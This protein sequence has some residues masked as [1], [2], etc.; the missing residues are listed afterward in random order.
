MRR[1]L[2]L[3]VVVLAIALTGCATRSTPSVSLVDMAFTE[4]TAF[5]TGAIFTVRIQNRTPDALRFKG[6]LHRVA[7]G[8]AEVGSGTSSVPFEVPALGET[9]QEVTVHFSNLLL[10]TRLR[11]MIE[12]RA[13][14]YRLDSTLY[15]VSGFGRS[16]VVKEGRIRLDDFDPNHT[17][18][19]R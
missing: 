14:D 15:P 12:A 19:I 10:V 4:A 1:P 7:L 11:G 6:A 16:H 17:A 8:G 5:E 13:V 2:P 9:T 18:P 3:L